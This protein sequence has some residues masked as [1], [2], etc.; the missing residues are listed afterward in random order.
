MI[1]FDDPRGGVRLSDAEIIAQANATDVAFAE[2]GTLLHLPF[3]AHADRA[4]ERIAVI[5]EGGAITYRELAQRA[6]RLADNLRRGGIG[7]GD[8]VAIA[9]DKGWEQIVAGLG[10]LSVGAIFVPIDPALPTERLHH[11]IDHSRAKCVVATEPV[12]T[13]VDWPAGT[14]RHLVRPTEYAAAVRRPVPRAVAEPDDLAYIIYTSGSTGQPKGV[15]ITHRGA[16]NTILD[17]NSRFEVSSADRVLAV[18]SFSFDL[19]IYD[20]FGTLAAGATVVLPARTPLPDPAAWLDAIR[21][22]EVTVWD[23]VPTLME[24]LVELAETRG[25]RGHMPTLR[26]A[27]LGGDWIDLRLPN[28]I[29]ALAPDCLV[30]STGGAT[31][32]SIW[33]LCYPIGKVDP[34]WRSIP[35]GRPLANQ[36]FHVLRPDG[37]P[38]AIGEIGELHISGVGVGAGYWRDAERTA[39]SFVR[40]HLTGETLYRTGDLGRYFRDGNL[41]FLGRKDFQVKIQGF[42]VELGEVEATLRQHPGVKDAAAVARP[43]PVGD[44]R[45]FGY[46]TSRSADLTGEQVRDFLRG[47]LPHYMVP[48]AVAVLDTLPLTTSGKIDRKALPAIDTS[49]GDTSSATPSSPLEEVLVSLWED[50][51][52]QEGLGT[53]ADFFALGGNSLRALRLVASVNAVLEV[54]VAVSQL[55]EAATPREFCRLFEADEQV[56]KQVCAVAAHIA[57]E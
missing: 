32:A 30:V 4:S 25:E 20:Y 45:L 22:H 57:A 36:R 49:G 43:D 38:C 15:M 42:R 8:I 44:R 51:L 6:D 52:A 31:E 29:H 18:S 23:S 5:H 53:D 33:S 9:M 41:E 16:V 13:R 1:S 24:M 11:L 12:D 21:S 2:A 50:V 26:L 37:T 40:D 48:D 27:L 19:A 56:W 10:V 17:I 34:N 39:A 35:Y 14:T 46:V 47:K 28:R 54:D 3:F 7:H 55:F